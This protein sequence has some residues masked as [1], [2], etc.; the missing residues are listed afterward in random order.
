MPMEHKLRAAIIAAI[1][2]PNRSP[3][4]YPLAV[5]RYGRE[6][7]FFIQP[8]GTYIVSLAK[9]GFQQ[10]KRRSRRPNQPPPT[11]NT[12][13]VKS[14]LSAALA[15]DFSVLDVQDCGT[16]IKIYIEGG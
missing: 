16:T 9:W 2:N 5:I 3:Y 14:A 10:Y 7:M 6:V 1:N 8:N 15:P 4:F 11:I 13:G 12:E